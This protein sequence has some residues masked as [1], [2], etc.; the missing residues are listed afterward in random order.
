MVLLISLGIGFAALQAFVVF[1]SF[2]GGGLQA[3]VGVDRAFAWVYVFPL[4]IAVITIA[5]VV[6]GVLSWI[7]SYWGVLARIYYSLTAVLALM[8]TLLLANLGL[9]T[10][11]LG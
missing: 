3:Y 10:V 11:L 5:I 1:A 2:G 9:M 6:L 4:L 8:Y 7:K